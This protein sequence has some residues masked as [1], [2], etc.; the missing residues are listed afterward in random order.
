MDNLGENLIFIIS[1]PRSGS[2]M[3]QHIL[4][5][6]SEVCTFPEPWFMLHLAYGLRQSGIK[7]EYE[8]Q[9]AYLALNDFLK[10]IPGGEVNYIDG[11]R[12]MAFQLYG[13]ALESSGKKYF[14]DKTT[15]YYFIVPELCRIFPKAKFIFLLR[16][17]LAVFS[18]LLVY[19]KGNWKGFL[20]ED[21]KHDILSAPNLILDGI[22]QFGEKAVVVHYEEIVSEP[23]RT[24]SNLCKGIGISFETGMLK[25][26]DKV[27]FKG[28]VFVDQ[29]SIYKH[30]S[31]VKDYKDN[32]LNQLSES[33][34]NIVLA[35]GYLSTLGRET[36]SSF[37]Y[38]YDDL[39]EKLNS[40]K[41][42][43][44]QV[45]LP[46]DTILSPTKKL[47]L[48]TRF[49]MRVSIIQNMGIGTFLRN[50]ASGI[51]KRR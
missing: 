1:Q 17:P 8:A 9:F 37:G 20:K 48:K 38:S 41:S 30:H 7:A 12:K 40:F 2:T 3:L 44:K 29:K 47:S 4:G 10:R 23:E 21:R 49:K 5:S 51:L 26:D 15:R 14:L 11:I 39:Y 34:Q 35:K 32:W 19:F 42:T 28:R 33:P 13:K 43:K 31:P 25:Y 27:H 22:K 24:I 50:L 16:N 36:V 45:V 46:W 6:H 18:S